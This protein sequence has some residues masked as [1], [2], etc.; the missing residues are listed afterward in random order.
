M[1]EVVNV[2]L[3]TVSLS[4]RVAPIDEEICPENI[5]QQSL[6]NSETSSIQ[7]FE[8][9]LPIT[10]SRK[11]NAFTAALHLLCSGIGV[12]ILLLPMAFVALGWSWGIVSLCM[13][14]LWQL[15][16]T[17][18]LVH[19][20]EPAPGIRYSRFLHLS[21]V[22][23]GPKLGK[24]LAI[25]PTMYLAGG[26]CVLF[27]INGG[28]II[29]LFY[30]VICGDNLQCNNKTLTGAQW[31]LVF[32]CLSI[33]LSQFFPNLNSLSR[34]SFVGSIMAVTYCS[35]IWILSVSTGPMKGIS[36][37][38]SEASTSDMVA[39]RNALNGIGYIALVFRGHNLVLEIQGTIRSNQKC[40]TSVP[41]WRGVTISYL[42]VAICLFPIAI[43]GYWAYGNTI[44]FNGG[45]L[46]ALMKFHKNNTSNGIPLLGKFG[47]IHRRN[48]IT[49]DIFL[50]M[51]HVDC[52]EETSGDES[53]VVPQRRSRLVGCVAQ[54]IITRFIFEYTNS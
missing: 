24:L 52:D 43:V 37:D 41:M 8:S 16:T 11:G 4:A 31:F 42:L 20:H 21:I 23:F 25:F 36:H 15:Y 27:I 35:M 1:A 38:P 18:I 5:N 2:R 7:G 33:L 46:S 47:F 29:E 26:T 45:I 12:Q 17:W 40:P 48:N 6:Q 32:V 50:S 14:F 13:A 34:V 22:A 30:K 53:N 3:E 9:W 54:L 44:P 49:V 19:L 10:E 51:L 39:I 28:W